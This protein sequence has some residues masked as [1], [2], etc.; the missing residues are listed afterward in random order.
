MGVAFQGF[1]P[2]PSPLA[3][4]SPSGRKTILGV[5][6]ANHRARGQQGCKGPVGGFDLLNLRPCGAW[7]TTFQTRAVSRS[8]EDP[9]EKPKEVGTKR[10]PVIS[11]SY[12]HAMAISS[13]I[14]ACSLIVCPAHLFEAHSLGWG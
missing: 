4:P 11:I 7:K 10:Y 2:Q 8:P 12:F 1:P 14:A 9:E 3:Q 5:A 13:V 6:P